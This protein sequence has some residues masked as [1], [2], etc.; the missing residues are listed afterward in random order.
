[1]SADLEAQR[2]EVERTIRLLAVAD[3]ARQQLET[4]V[5]DLQGKLDDAMI[6]LAAASSD[7]ETSRQSQALLEQELDE[8]QSRQAALTAD[9]VARR[10][11]GELVATAPGPAPTRAEAVDPV[12]GMTVLVDDAKYH[13]VHEGSDYW[14]CAPGCQRAFQSDP[15]SFPASG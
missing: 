6:S 10:A 11:R 1:M 3:Q 2:Q 13:T 5:A 7:Y 9:L 12:C 15:L 8:A 14:F 4:L